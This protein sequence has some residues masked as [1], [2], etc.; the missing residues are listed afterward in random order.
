MTHNVAKGFSYVEV[1]I[2]II[3]IGLAIVPVIESMNIGVQS[4][5]H[6]EDSLGVYTKLSSTY[7]TLMAESFKDLENAAAQAGDPEIET[8]YSDETGIPNRCLVYIHEYD[9]DNSDNDG[10]GFT[11]TDED[12]LWIKIQIENSA[13]QLET[14]VV[15]R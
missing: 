1:I 15:K 8:H 7:E 12:V 3:I 9:L 4:T 14:L 5:R 2:A 11:G 13:H 6:H 10:A